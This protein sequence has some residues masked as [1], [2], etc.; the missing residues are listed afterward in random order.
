MINLSVLLITQFQILKKNLKALIVISFLLGLNIIYSQSN[1]Q[2]IDTLN[3][4]E[5]DKKPLLL[6]NIKYDASDSIVIDQKNNKIILYNNAKIVYG[7]IELTSGLI[8]LD[9][10]ENIVNAGRIADS[11]GNLSQYPTFKQG[12]NIVNPDSIKYNFDNQ[13]ALIWN[14]K[15]EDNGMNILSTLT[16]KQNDSVYYLKDGKVTTGGNLMGDETEE[17]DYFFKIRKGKLVPGGNI[18]TGFHEFI[19]K[20]CSY[21]N[22]STICIF[23]ISTNKRFWLYNS[24]Y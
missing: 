14:S 20:K 5:Q 3:F 4:V 11:K 21:S 2:E 18:V 13:K 23:P 12:G 6:D 15:S 24:K 1:S 10:K 9:Y 7:D 16:K 17:A 22:W 8:I 19:C